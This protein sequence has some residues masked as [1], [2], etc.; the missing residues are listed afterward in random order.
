MTNFFIPPKTQAVLD[1]LKQVAEETLERKR[2]LGHYAVVWRDE[3]VVAVGGDDA[4]PELRGQMPMPKGI[5]DGD[6]VAD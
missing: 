1:M 4:P 2:R 6:R 5:D 3:K